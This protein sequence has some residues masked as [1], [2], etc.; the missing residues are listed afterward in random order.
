MIS[1]EKMQQKVQSSMSVKRYLHTLGVVEEAK[2]MAAHYGDESLVHKCEVAALLHDIAKEYPES[3]ITQL[4][5]EYK[6]CQEDIYKENKE[7]IHAVLGAES[8]KREYKIDDQDILNGI[9]YHTVG[10]AEMSLLEKIVYIADYTEPNRK[11]FPGLLEAR[12]LSYENL[13]ATMVLIFEQT[14][15]FLASKNSEIHPESLKALAYYKERI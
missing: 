6:V 9:L 10:R 2:K 15:V 14:K 4:C 3:L 5:R 12:T 8:A 13:D 7:L 1:M 11:N